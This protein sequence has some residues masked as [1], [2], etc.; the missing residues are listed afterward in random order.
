MTTNRMER[1]KADKET[2]VA[3]FEKAPLISIRVLGYSLSRPDS[4]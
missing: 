1:F 4:E 3:I 2:H